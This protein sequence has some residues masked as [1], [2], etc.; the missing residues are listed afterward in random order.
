RIE[1]AALAD[2]ESTMGRYRMR[3]L[4]R[5]LA[6]LSFVIVSTSAWSQSAN[7]PI[8]N[9]DWAG[10]SNGQYTAAGWTCD[11]DHYSLALT[12]HFYIDGTYATGTFVGAAAANAY[13]GDVTGVCG[14][15][16]NHGYNFTI[17]SQYLPV[18]QHTLYAY[19]L[20][21]G[22]IGPNPLLG[23]ITFTVSAP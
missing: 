15:T 14:G 5:F 20:D 8:G 19:A 10:L 11:P 7:P 9:A 1:A 12:I 3:I 13:R 4:R 23:A 6:F 2:R 17:P 16:A 18:G 21:N 22:G